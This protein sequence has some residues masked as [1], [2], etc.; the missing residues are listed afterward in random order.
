MPETLL[1]PRGR[2]YRLE[3]SFDLSRQRGAAHREPEGPQDS[4]VLPMSVSRRQS[5]RPVRHYSPPEEIKDVG[6]RPDP[7]K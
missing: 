4:V 3:Q 5:V 6:R 1:V 2:L 7:S